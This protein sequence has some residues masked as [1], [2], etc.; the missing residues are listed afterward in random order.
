M[1]R[2]ALPSLKIPVAALW[3]ASF[4]ALVAYSTSVDQA[5]ASGAQADVLSIGG[6]VTEIVYALGQEHRLKARDTT[7]TWPAEVQE[8]PNVG[9]MRA[10][11]PEGVLSV[12]PSL[13]IS[14]EGAGPQETLDVLKA[15]QVKFVEIPDGFDRDAIVAKINAV[16]AALEVTDKSDALAR[17]VS[18]ALDT[19]AATIAA[20]DNVQKRVL[21]ILSAR[22]GKLMVGGANT[23]ADGIITM[24]GGIN[25]AANIDGFKP[26]TDE[27]AATIA[28]D[29]ILMMDRGG[30]HAM[31]AAELFA[32]PALSITPAAKTQA[33]VRMNGLLM[34]GFGPRTAQAVTELNSALYGE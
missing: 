27:A 32:M 16:G 10:L 25:A 11:S 6:S 3:V 4:G 31:A 23:P 34:L 28:P 26:L 19:V 13:I 22:G 24:A 17:E 1:S 7:S 14:E 15:A 2:F 8:L 21:F 18:A 30:D 20:Q 12:E 5:T 33:V 9:Y 29:V